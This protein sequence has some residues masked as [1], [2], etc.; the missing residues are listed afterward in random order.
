MTNHD[1]RP[2]NTAQST[3]SRP[4]S[5]TAYERIEELLNSG[6]LRPGQVV[7]QRELVEMTDATLGSIRIAIPRLEAEGLL[8]TLP[9]RGLMIPSLDVTFVRDAYQLRRLIEVGALETAASALDRAL[10]DD[11]IERH[12]SMLAQVERT[13]NS[14][15]TAEMQS[16][17]WQMHESIVAS[18]GNRLIDNTYRVT[19]IK[20][21]MVVQSRLQITSGNA[22]RV[23][24]EHL[25]FLRPLAEGDTDSARVALTRHIDNS[26]ALALGTRL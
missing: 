15:M 23:L 6:T 24:E 19:S 21:R 9:K 2:S 3:E 25:A 16:L 14:E 4:L 17:D 26:L 22:K 7:S 12:L 5:R 10:V 11:W 20:I 8:Q 18:M 1:E 13:M